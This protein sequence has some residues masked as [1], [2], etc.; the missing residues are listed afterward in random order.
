[1]TEQRQV[2]GASLQGENAAPVLDVQ[3]GHLEDRRNRRRQTSLQV[4]GTGQRPRHRELGLRSFSQKGLF[5]LVQDLPR[6]VSLHN[7][8]TDLIALTI[9]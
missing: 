4:R 8:V 7:H 5:P 9:A 1:M 6:D 3:T 2:P